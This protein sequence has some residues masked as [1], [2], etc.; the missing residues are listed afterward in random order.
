MVTE[1]TETLF[2]DKTLKNNLKLPKTNEAPF[3]FPKMADKNSNNSNLIDILYQY[4]SHKRFRHHLNHL[5]GKI[6]SELLIRSIHAIIPGHSEQA[7][8]I[9]STTMVDLDG[10]LKSVF[11]VDNKDILFN[12]NTPIIFSAD[13]SYYYNRRHVILPPK[14]QLVTETSTVRTIVNACGGWKIK[15]WPCKT[16][17][18]PT[19]PHGRL[20][21]WGTVAFWTKSG[22]R[23]TT[24][25]WTETL[26]D[27]FWSDISWTCRLSRRWAQKSC[28]HRPIQLHDI[29]R[30]SITNFALI[31]WLTILMYWR[32]L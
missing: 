22:T 21:Y 31:T 27:T 25:S 19:H 18:H 4:F 16:K 11:L 3:E 29:L 6:T 9:S 5:G 10:Q 26:P 28:S 1:W 7:L 17:T 13:P 12:L 32:L 24:C 15:K 20:A 8:D 14:I 30:L 2:D 23:F